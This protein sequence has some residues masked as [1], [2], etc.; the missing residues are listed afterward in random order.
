MSWQQL[1]VMFI[2][3][4]IY[5]VKLVVSG[6]RVKLLVNMIGLVFLAAI[7]SA[8]ASSALAYFLI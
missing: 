7:F 3:V 6:P 5:R 1:V 4:F 8:I 2:D